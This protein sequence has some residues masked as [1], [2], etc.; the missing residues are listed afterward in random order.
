MKLKTLVLF[1][2]LAL[3]LSACAPERAQM[4]E[5]TF[6]TFGTEVSIQIHH[7][8]ADQAQAAIRDIEQAFYRFNDQWHAWQPDSMVSQI[9]QALAAGQSIEVDAQTRV[10]I[11]T[12]QQL[13]QQSDYLFDPAIGELIALWGF[14]QAGDFTPPSEQA[15]Q[16]WLVSRPSIADLYF[17]DNRLASHNNKVKLDFGG[18][19]K[20]LALNIAAEHLATHGIKNALINI[21]GD[22]LVVGQRQDQSPWRIG[23]TDPHQPQQAIAQ[24]KAYDGDHIF[25]SGT[26]QRYFEW[27]GQRYS[28][29]INPNTAWPADSFASVTVI[30]KD[31]IRADTA[32]TAILIAGPEHWQRIAQQLQVD[33][34]MTIDQQGQVY[35]TAAMQHHLQK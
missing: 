19:A 2:L 4:I 32:A 15:R 12:T 24:L 30:N 14:Q 21:G 16:T 27:Q 1:P 7:P 26:Y 13:S 6:Y 17:I 23:L 10:F 25:T 22:I 11:E 20:G 33:K 29:I 34:V 3:L 8:N 31:A 18:N 35:V 28:H 5:Q 9:N